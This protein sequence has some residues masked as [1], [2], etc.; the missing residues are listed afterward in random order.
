[1]LRTRQLPFLE[2][3]GDGLGAGV[4]GGGHGKREEPEPLLDS[5]RGLV[6]MPEYRGEYDPCHQHR[7]EPNPEQLRHPPRVRER[8]LRYHQHLHPER[9]RKRR[10]RRHRCREAAGVPR[11]ELP[12]RHACADRVLQRQLLRGPI[13]VFTVA[14]DVVSGLPC[15]VLSNN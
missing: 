9:I 15:P 2:E 10:H 11:H 12:R 5:L 1:M 8:P 7:P 4:E 14:V 13:V 6:E 3:D